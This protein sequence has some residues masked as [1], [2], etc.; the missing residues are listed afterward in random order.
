MVDDDFECE[1]FSFELFEFNPFSFVSLSSTPC[2]EFALLMAVIWLYKMQGNPT[3]VVISVS[4]KISSQRENR[5]RLNWKFT[6]S[7]ANDNNKKLRHVR[8]AK[9][10]LILNMFFLFSLWF[11]VSCRL[12]S[13]VVHAT[14]HS[15]A[16]PHPWT[17]ESDGNR[18]RLCYLSMSCRRRARSRYLVVASSKWKYV[19]G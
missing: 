13:F 16:L 7:S 6:V 10:I 4:H 11:A 8:L 9:G 1:N 18:R 15:T 14:Q 12:S 19:I 3:M 17:A 2:T 5:S